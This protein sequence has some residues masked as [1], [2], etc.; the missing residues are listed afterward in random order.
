MN[1]IVSDPHNPDDLALF[2][3][4]YAALREATLGIAPTALK[5]AVARAART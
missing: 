3:R 4:L 1:P 5:R 2:K